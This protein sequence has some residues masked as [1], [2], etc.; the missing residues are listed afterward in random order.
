MA[1][2]ELDRRSPI[3]VLKD[4]LNLAQ[5]WGTAEQF[6]RSLDDDLARN[7][8]E[9]IVVIMNRGI[10]RGHVGVRELADALGQE[11]PEH[12]SFHYD[13]VAVDGGLGLLEWTYEDSQVRV[14]DG[15]DSYVIEGG[16]IVGQTIHYTLEPKT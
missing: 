13:F 4:H 12:N 15:V 2:N 7:V 9:E 1:A 3:E 6:Q 8:S 10:F 5:D 14:R 11:L 16:K